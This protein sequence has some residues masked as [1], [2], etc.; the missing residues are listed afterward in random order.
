[1]KGIIP[2]GGRGTRMRPV[3]FSANKHFI[4]VANKPLIFYPIEALVSAGITDILITYNPG[5]LE[6]VK[7]LLGNGKKFGAKF[8]YVLQEEPKGLADIVLSCKDYLKDESFCFHLGDNIFVDGIKELADYFQEEKPNGLVAMVKH[9]ENSRMGVPYFDKKGNLKKIVEK[10]SKP[11]HKYAMPGIYFADASFFKAFR[12]KDKVKPSA[13]G[14]WEIPDPFTWMINHGYKVMVKE[15]EGKW[16]DPGKFDDWLEANMYLLDK[17][18]DESTGSARKSG[19]VTIEGRVKFGKNVKVKN[20]KIRGP[21]AMGDNVVI[22]NS[23]VG[24][25]TSIYNNCELINCRVENSVLMNSVK[26]SNLNRLVD[27][28]ILGS[29]SEIQSHKHG[30]DQ[31]E[32]FL[33]SQSKVIL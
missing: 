9:E 33:D 15:Y 13:R 32:L 2:T 25:Y 26:I 4:P 5:F 12:G 14:E 22:K 24:P 19:K 31:V 27:S 7:D 23:Y 18:V 11:P 10:P 30:G 17:Q 16:L 1:M 20:S 6:A 21:V 28:S 29:N 8:S 3:T